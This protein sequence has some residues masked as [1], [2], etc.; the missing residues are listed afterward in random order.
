MVNDYEIVFPSLNG[1]YKHK[2]TD[3]QCLTERL[4]EIILGGGGDNGEGPSV[5]H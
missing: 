3:I 4:N 2:I 5:K 1:G